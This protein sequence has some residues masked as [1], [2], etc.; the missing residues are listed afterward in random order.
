MQVLWFE[1][2]EVG[3]ILAF[4]LIAMV[5]GGVTWFFLIAGPWLYSRSK[6]KYPRGFLLHIL[7][8]IGVIQL[9]FYPDYFEDIFLE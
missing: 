9:E 5:F 4:G 7:Y 2:D 6:K 1:T 3:I 8:F